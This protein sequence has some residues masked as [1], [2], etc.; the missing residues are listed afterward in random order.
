MRFEMRQCLASLT[1]IPFP[2]RSYSI[3]FMVTQH[4]EGPMDTDSSIVDQ[5]MADEAEP[6]CD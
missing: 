5:T 1:S 2:L 3:R 6:S 4:S